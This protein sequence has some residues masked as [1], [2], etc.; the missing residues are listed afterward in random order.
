MD[1]KTLELIES[2]RHADPRL[3]ELMSTHQELNRQV[4]QLNTRS[5][6]T[7]EEHQE[8]SRLKKE[9]LKV[10]DHIETIVHD[11]KASA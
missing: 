2:L 9:K 1:Q 4:D 11:Q 8:L 5:F 10:R 3:N 6:L 7:D